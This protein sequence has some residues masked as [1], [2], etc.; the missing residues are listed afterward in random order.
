MSLSQEDETLHTATVLSNGAILGLLSFE[1]Y[2][3]M[4]N[5][6]TLNLIDFSQVQRPEVSHYA[7]TTNLCKMK[8]APFEKDGPCYGRQFYHA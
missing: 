3:V 1:S 7:V 8:R 2:G 4:R 5:L 6:R